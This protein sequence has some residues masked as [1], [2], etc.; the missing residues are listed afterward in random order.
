MKEVPKIGIDLGAGLKPYPL[1]LERNVLWTGTM[2]QDE[3][4]K[5]LSDKVL[6]R[7]NV[8][9]F[10]RP[11]KLE[12]RKKLQLSE[13]RPMI[14]FKVWQTWCCLES[15]LTE[16]DIK[17]YK[18][19]LEQMNLHLESAGRAL[20]HRIWQSLE[21]YIANYPEVIAAKKKNLDKSEI[22]S[23]MKRAFEDQLVQKVMTKLRGIETTGTTK[24]KCLDP[25]RKQIEDFGLNLVTDFD[26]ACKAGYGQFVWNSANYLEDSK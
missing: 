10:P 13:A 23:A 1:K 15:N 3:T 9:S 20:G 12:R 6:D 11:K 5:S 19:F 22:E 8:I 4:T 2:N 26:L 18:E 16:D 7:G 21:C 24:T 25:I 14:Q 17:P